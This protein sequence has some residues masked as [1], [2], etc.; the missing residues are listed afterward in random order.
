[1]EHNFP[2]NALGLKRGSIIVS[3][4]PQVEEQLGV[5]VG[6]SLPIGFD[7]TYV[8]CAGFTWSIEQLVKEIR[9]GLWTINNKCVDLSSEEARHE[10]RSIVERT[11]E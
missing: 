4:H 9:Y 6:D 11:A 7:G 10:F 2:A 1:M 8:C 3:A 5:K